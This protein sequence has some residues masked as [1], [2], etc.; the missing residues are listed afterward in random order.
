M[1]ADII[2]RRYIT[3]GMAALLLMVP[4]AITST[5][6]WVRRLG[7]KRWQKLHR[8]GLLGALRGRDPLLL[9]GQI[10][11]PP[12]ADVRRDLAVLLLY[13]VI[14]HVRTPRRVVTRRAPAPVG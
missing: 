8:I 9:A 12:A 14:K 3:I 2:K 10:G 7:Y 6:G 11:H 1:W 5:A 13:R 4:L